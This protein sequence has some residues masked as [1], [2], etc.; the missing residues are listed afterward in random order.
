MPRATFGA[1]FSLPHLG[2]LTR[3]TSFE[4]SSSSQI[5]TPGVGLLIS[6][7]IYSLHNYIRTIGALTLVIV[8]D[9]VEA[10]PFFLAAN[11]FFRSD[12]SDPGLSEVGAVAFMLA[13]PVLE[14]NHV[15]EFRAGVL[16]ENARHKGEIGT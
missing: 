1:Q 11:H 9:D 7:P 8:G 6:F 13:D 5:S 10:V 3:R 16:S 15:T 2:H 4:P 14:Y 12:V